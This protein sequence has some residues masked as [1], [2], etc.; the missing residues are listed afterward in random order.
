VS[1]EKFV[2]LAGIPVARATTNVIEEYVSHE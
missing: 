2:A 1:L